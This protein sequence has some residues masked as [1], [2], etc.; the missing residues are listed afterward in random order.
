MRINEENIHMGLGRHIFME[1]WTFTWDNL[2][3][4]APKI[5]VICSILVV[6]GL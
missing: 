4:I 5:V 2:C 6:V 3:E 1:V